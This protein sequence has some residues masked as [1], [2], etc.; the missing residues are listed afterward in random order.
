MTFICHCEEAELFMGADEAIFSI[1]A[2]LLVRLL[3]R[4]TRKAWAPRND[5]GLFTEVL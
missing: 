1:E 2:S 5:S 4:P 3:R